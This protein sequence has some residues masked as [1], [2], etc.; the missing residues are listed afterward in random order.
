MIKRI[1]LAD[2]DADDISLFDE[3]LREI[4]AS[5]EFTAAEN[6]KEL[7]DKLTGSKIAPQVIFL[8][9]NMPEMNGWE[10]LDTIK[11]TS[12]LKD[13]PV[14]MYST[15]SSTKDGRRAIE[16]GALGFYEKPTSYVKLKDFLRVIS[17]VTV[18]ALPA[19]LKKL[20]D[21]GEHR[22]FLKQRD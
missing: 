2:D 11:E 21:S 1:F 15:S 14:I 12:A 5:I 9:V 20:N 7:I 22:V 19:T 10:A 18:K 6:G 13:I 8:D 3:A 16:S 4:D 17:S